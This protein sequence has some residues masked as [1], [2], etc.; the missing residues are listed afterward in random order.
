[1]VMWVAV[2]T[3][4]FSVYQRQSRGVGPFDLRARAAIARTYS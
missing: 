2:C 1:M 4:W 3:M